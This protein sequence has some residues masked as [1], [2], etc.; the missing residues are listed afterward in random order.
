MYR[1]VCG[2]HIANFKAVFKK[3]SVVGLQGWI[4][5]DVVQQT[6]QPSTLRE[7]FSSAV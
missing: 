4:M 3:G 5:F 2:I 7:L 6:E 1:L